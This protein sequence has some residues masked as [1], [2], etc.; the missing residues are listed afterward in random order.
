MNHDKQN[1]LAR[2]WTS[3]KDLFAPPRVRYVRR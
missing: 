2:F 1:T 3:V